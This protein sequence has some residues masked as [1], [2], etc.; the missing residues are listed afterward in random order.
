MQ[1][2]TTR[3]TLQNERAATFHVKHRARLVDFCTSNRRDR[4]D[5]GPLADRYQRGCFT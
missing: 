4:H 5:A 1:L 3:H 2:R